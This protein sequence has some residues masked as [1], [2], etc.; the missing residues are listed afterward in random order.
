MSTNS[1]GFYGIDQKVIEE[2]MR[3]AR[4]ER[5]KAI[6]EMVSQLFPSVADNTAE[7]EQSRGREPALVGGATAAHL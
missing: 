3:K 4:R 1:Y 2:S 6:W 7:D 5:S